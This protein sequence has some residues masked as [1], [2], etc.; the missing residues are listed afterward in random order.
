VHFLI[1][2]GGVGASL[3]PLVR[4][5]FGCGLEKGCLIRRTVQEV[6]GEG[7]YDIRFMIYEVGCGLWVVG[8]RMPGVTSS[9]F[10]VGFSWLLLLASF[11]KR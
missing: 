3:P 10:V 1:P 6:W 5:W 9:F 4:V 7:I 11:G 8:C 2:S